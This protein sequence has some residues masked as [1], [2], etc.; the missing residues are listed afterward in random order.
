MGTDTRIFD[1]GKGYGPLTNLRTMVDCT[2]AQHQGRWWMCICG[3]ERGSH[4]IHLYS[5]TLPEGAALSATGWTVTAKPEDPSRPALAAGKK[6]SHWWD[7]T[8]GRHCPSYAKGWDPD[9]NAWVERIYYA[10]A[11]RDF[12]GPYA[13][14]YL[15]WD[16]AEWVDQAAPAF[17]ANEYWERGSVYEPN[18]IYHDGK[19]KMW[20]V[21]GANQDDY[22]V[23]GYAESPDGRTGWSHHRIVF[24][25]EEK[26]FDFCVLPVAGGF[27]AVFAQVNVGKAEL[28][29]T[30]LWWTHAKEPSPVISDWSEPV[31]LSGPGPW[32]PVLSYDEKNPQKMFV[33]YD[34]QY[35]NTTG[36]GIP[37]HF[38]LNCLEIDR[39]A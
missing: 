6:R 36:I 2:V 26:V 7:G 15:E 22:L 25:P 3:V 4:E 9:K 5:A 19:W 13:I 18:L 31:R 20:Y 35:T 24:A 38:T 1:A 8:G 14:G 12:M 11:A 17:T 32:K 37:F 16:G 28:P 34:G 27:E 23:H 21:A 33:F 30:G 39:P 29:K 10:G